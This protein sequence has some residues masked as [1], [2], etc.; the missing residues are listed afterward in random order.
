MYL[1]GYGVPGDLS[2][3]ERLIRSAA[4]RG[5]IKAQCSLATMYMN[6]EGYPKIILKH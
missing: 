1:D 4:D 5:N 3:A 6:G 2:A